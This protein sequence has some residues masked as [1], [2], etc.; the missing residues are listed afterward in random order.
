MTIH[1]TTVLLG[2]LMFAACAESRPAV[3]IGSPGGKL[4]AELS[5]DEGVLNYR[6]MAGKEQ[7]LGPSRLGIVTASADFSQ[8]LLADSCTLPFEGFY[9][10]NFPLGRQVV[11][12]KP[13]CEQTLFVRNATGRGWVSRFA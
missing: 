5:L 3:T 1:M 4:K 10:Y 8:G 2:V 6:L 9:D 11:G 12:N 7:L 13:Y